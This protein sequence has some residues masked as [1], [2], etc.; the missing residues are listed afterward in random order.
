MTVG[1]TVLEYALS[2]ARAGS[3]AALPLSLGTTEVAANR[4]G[5]FADLTASA[6]FLQVVAGGV[7]GPIFQRAG[8]NVM[9][10]GLKVQDSTFQILDNLDNSKSIAWQAG[11]QGSGLQFTFDIG[12]QAGNRTASIPVLAGTDTFAMLGVANTFTLVNTFS[13]AT[14]A[15]T[16]QLGA[17]VQN[18]GTAATSVAIG[19]GK[20]NFGSTVTLGDQL[21]YRGDALGGTAG[22][23]LV[24]SQYANAVSDGGST[25]YLLTKAWRTGTFSSHSYHHLAIQR[26]VDA[27]PMNYIAWRGES[28]GAAGLRGIAF[29]YNDPGTPSTQDQIVFSGISKANS[30]ANFYGTT[31]ATASN[32][33]TLMVGDM[34]AATTVAFGG[35]N[36]NAGGAIT[37][38]T[39]TL[40]GATPVTLNSTSNLLQI[41]G[42]AS[43]AGV[44]I[45]SNADTI[46]QLT[47]NSTSSIVT[48]N[49]YKGTGAS[50]ALTL[51]DTG[52]ANQT[53]LT[54]SNAGVANFPTTTS[55]SSSIAGAVTIGN[56][57]AAT[58]AA[59]GAGRANFGADGTFGDGLAVNQIIK[60]TGSP[61]LLTLTGAAHTTLTLSVEAS[62]F[63]ANFART[64]Q[65][66]TGPLTT[67][68][69]FRVMAP[70][71]GF[72]GASTITNA[73]TFAISGAPIAGTFATLTNSWALW[74]QSGGS[75]FDAG[76]LTAAQPTIDSTATWN[77]GGVAFTGVRHNVTD[78]ASAAASLLMDLQLGGA[79]RF[80]VDKFGNATHAQGVIT[81]GSPALLTLTGGAHTTLT[82]SVEA[83]DVVLNLARTVQ[84]ATGALA[85][86]RAV[87]VMAPTYAFVAAST[88]TTAATLAVSGAPV[89]GT[90]ATL[91]NT[92][93]LW[94]QSGGSRFDAGT[95][96]AA[97]PTIDSTATWNAGAVTFTAVRHNVTDTASAAGSILFD[98]QLGGTSRF[99]VDKFGNT[100]LAQGVITTGTPN[101]FKVTGGAH[102]T[103]SASNQ[104]QDVLINLNRVVQWATG[105]IPSQ[106]AFSIIHP[107]YAF[108]GASTIT[109]AATF[110]ITN[111]PTAGTNATITNAYALW[112][113]AGT[114]RFDGTV[115]A[116]A[117]IQSI[118]PTAGIGYATGAGGT[119]TQATSRATG[120]TL[121]KV[122][123]QITLFT[124]AGSATP[125]TFVVTNTT[126]A[127]TD[128]IVITDVSGSTNVY[129]WKATAAAGSF[130]VTFWTTGGVASDTPIIQFSVHKAV[131]A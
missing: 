102:T 75:R 101:I 115:Q 17:I 26:V 112:V 48:L 38:L 55:A 43:N 109:T 40:S 72:V 65:F 97:Q 114:S 123:G 30:I 15:T 29:G 5:L 10:T 68:R 21:N 105:P 116:N 120:V 103:L 22:N 11:T 56:G 81:T 18:S 57:V 85:T 129:F 41:S 32:A 49:G 52:G 67:Q 19:A 78:T 121:S 70:T 61:A 92:W 118:S 45:L 20:G 14:S 94:V 9:M 36:I 71:Y 33:G 4:V 122:C 95:I 44:Y 104:V 113:E 106:R 79:T 53:R 37:G 86:Q 80:N 100:T 98:L 2:V 6:E 76:T 23:S 130:T 82:L 131:T 8:A 51:A 60:T 46:A 34:V 13:N 28:G 50:F 47:A 89:A 125:A 90:F 24:L 42:P 84:F 7:S 73:A 126:V 111:A 96:T 124:A 74:V 1:A 93:A 35:G 3:A 39:L 69:A 88:I 16:S 107:T 63:I 128:S 127:A 66:A 91:T 64:V 12:A 77:N 119:V 27:S 108:V 87:R 58:S 99:N 25:V 54:V 117:A 62:D 59:I 110:A 83:S 31:G